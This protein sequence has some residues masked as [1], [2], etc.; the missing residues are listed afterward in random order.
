MIM[1]PLLN[2]ICLLTSLAATA[3]SNG[4]LNGGSTSNGGGGAGGGAG[5]APQNGAG[6]SGYVAGGASSQG[7]AGASGYGGSGGSAQSG[8]GTSGYSGSGGSAQS[9]AGTSGANAG[10]G[11]QG[12]SGGT[13]GAPVTASCAGS[14]HPLCIDFE[15]GK[16]DAPWKLPASNAKVEDGKAAHG[17]YAMHISGLS[18]MPLPELY[19][20]TSLKGFKDV[21]WGRFYLYMDPGAPVGHG[22]L[23]RVNDTQGH[24]NEVGFES[25]GA[26][27][28]RDN[29][30][31]PSPGAYFADWHEAAA[32]P[33]EKYM[34]SKSTIPQKVWACVEFYFDGATPAL[35]QVWGDSTE[36]TFDDIGGAAG[37]TQKAVQFTDF[38]IGIVFYHGGSLVTYEGDDTLP[39]ITDEWIDDIALDTK[40]VGC[41]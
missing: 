3:C 26:D 15:S 32:G 37:D 40:R 31:S 38:N 7:T 12:G 20:S 27:P 11:G 33:D 28:T 4:S 39:V 29:D 23:V 14:E 22:A 5:A 2:G 16:A 36:V 8:A 6:M 17:R 35:P 24:W 25:N 21:M 13:A 9:G 19:L 18:S 1:K 30:H 34:R 41:L 10:T